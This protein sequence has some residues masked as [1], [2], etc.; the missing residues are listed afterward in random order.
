MLYRA[1]CRHRARP[2][3]VAKMFMLLLSSS[4]SF[5]HRV[6]CSMAAGPSKFDPR[7]TTPDSDR[8]VWLSLWLTATDATPCRGLATVRIRP[9]SNVASSR[10]PPLPLAVAVAGR[11]DD[12]ILCICAAPLSV[13]TTNLRCRQDGDASGL[14]LQD[15]SG[16]EPAVVPHAHLLVGR[17]IPRGNGLRTV[18]G[19]QDCNTDDVIVVG[20]D[21]HG[22]A[23]RRAEVEATEAAVRTANK[24]PTNGGEPG[25]RSGAATAAGKTEQRLGV[26]ST[27]DV[28]HKTAG[29]QRQQL[30]AEAVS[31]S[32]ATSAAV[33]APTTA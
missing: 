16:V 17:A 29:R 31:T 9:P 18:V 19:R 4:L 6:A 24:D 20:N 3:M 26:A 23:R 30:A 13:V 15:R 28:P 14:H 25:Q 21:N 33:D 5:G 1:L 22:P 2:I 32:A 7:R 11:D 8:A 12:V 10:R 27:G